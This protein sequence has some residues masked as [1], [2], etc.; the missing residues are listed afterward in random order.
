MNNLF[1]TV[2]YTLVDIT[3]TNVVS[4]DDSTQRNEHRNWETL[5]QVLGL[6]AQLMLLNP[7]ALAEVDLLVCKFGA[8]F[9]GKHRVWVFKFGVESEGVF[10]DGN[11]LYGTL[12]RDFVNVPIILGLNETAPIQMPTFAV[13]GSSRNIYFEPFKI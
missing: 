13:S 10:A 5:T 1:L 3:Q 2:G 11:N 4:S 8:D 6:R 7:P 9:V 12:E